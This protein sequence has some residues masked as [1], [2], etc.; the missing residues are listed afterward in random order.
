MP[1]VLP[2]APNKYDAK[3]EQTTRNNI[4]AEDVNNLKKNT[5]IYLGS[6]SFV[7]KSPNGTQWEMSVD[8]TGALVMTSI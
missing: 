2:S 8:N 1:L 3:N 5:R 7:F 6:G 4:V